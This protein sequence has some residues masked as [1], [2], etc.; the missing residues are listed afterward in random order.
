MSEL[1]ASLFSPSRDSGIALRGSLNRDFA[2]SYEHIL[3][4][5]ADHIEIPESQVEALLSRIRAGARETP[6]LFSLHF[7]LLEAIEDDRLD[8]VDALIARIVSVEPAEPGILLTTFDPV[9]FPWDWETVAGYFA[10]ENDSLFRYVP[11][12]ADLVPTRMAQVEDALEL[13]RQTLPGLAAELNEVITTVIL[14]S[15][16]SLADEATSVMP[17]QGASALRAFGATVLDVNSD[18]SVVDCASSLIHEEAHS[19]L[20][21]LSPMDGVVTN[22]DDERH[23][24]PLRDDPRPLEGI[25]HATFVLARISFGMDA[26]LSSGQ[27]A[28]DERDA[29]TEVVSNSRPL[30]FD[31]LT[32]LRRHANLTPAGDA[33]LEA[34]ETYMAAYT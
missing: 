8:E 3:Q 20:Y 33:A 22:P 19:T 29:A 32:T 13:I 9:D 31:G 27:L 17:F 18:Q 34:A 16:V 14:A 23:S 15:G 4:A 6:F 11:P 12:S 5:C 7:K 28:S 10:A 21:A 2:R 25:F 30:F 1:S 24:S 26:M